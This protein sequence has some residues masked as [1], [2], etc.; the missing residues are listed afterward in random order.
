MRGAQGYFLKNFKKVRKSQVAGIKKIC[1]GGCVGH[2]C[3]GVD[4]ALSAGAGC[5]LVGVVGVV[6]F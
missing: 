1:G 6:G 5:G 2:E 3:E 4:H